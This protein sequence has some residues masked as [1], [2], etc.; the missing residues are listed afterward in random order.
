MA[1]QLLVL[2]RCGAIHCECRVQDKKRS[3]EV[4][5]CDKEYMSCVSYCNCCDDGLG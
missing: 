5:D 4:C 1:S 3:T 2:L